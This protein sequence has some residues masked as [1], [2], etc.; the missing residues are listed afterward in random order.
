MDEELP[1]QPAAAVEK[2]MTTRGRTR[3][4]PKKSINKK[5][6]S[7]EEVKMPSNTPLASQKRL[8][9]LVKTSDK[10][11]SDQPNPLP[12]TTSKRPSQA[13]SK[14]HSSAHSAHNSDDDGSGSGNSSDNDDPRIKK[15]KDQRRERYEKSE[16]KEEGKPAKKKSRSKSGAGAKKPKSGGKVAN[17]TTPAKAPQEEGKESVKASP[18]VNIQRREQTPQVQSPESST[19][20]VNKNKSAN[21]NSSVK[22]SAVKIKTNTQQPA[23]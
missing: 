4:Q 19:R 23:L 16:K 22:S 7:V 1:V 5:N 2:A 9:T 17:P 13:S 15:Q 20:K 21:K 6:T 12:A 8:H 3:A 10:L 11:T 14:L 18:S